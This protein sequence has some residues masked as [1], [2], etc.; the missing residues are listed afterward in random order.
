MTHEK[1]IALVGDQCKVIS[2]HLA[3]TDFPDQALVR[4]FII[5][6][7]EIKASIV[8]HFPFF[9]EMVAYAIAK[10]ISLTGIFGFGI[11]AKHGV[12]RKEAVCGNYLVVVPGHIIQ[13]H[14]KMK[15]V[16]IIIDRNTAILVTI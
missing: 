14:K 9:T 2:N 7:V 13:V 11:L 16:R 8:I 3:G 4:A 5:G 10:V 1:C 12:R 15:F 6:V